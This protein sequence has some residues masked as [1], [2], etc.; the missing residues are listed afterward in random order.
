MEQFLHILDMTEFWLGT[1][2]G[3]ILIVIEYQTPYAD[4]IENFI[5]AQENKLRDLGDKY[6]KNS[7]YS[8]IFSIAV[9]LT[10]FK[11]YT[12]IIYYSPV[13]FEL[14]MPNF[15]YFLINGFLIF[16]YGILG[17]YTLSAL[18]EYANKVNNGKAIGGIG[19]MIDILCMF[20]GITDK[21]LD[22]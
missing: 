17:L 18:I 15:I 5:D 4:K 3:T 8:V 11:I 16:T 9:P 13:V 12:I 2:I 7:F 21:L 14:D 6:T 10:V 1:I 20:I 19:I 22:S